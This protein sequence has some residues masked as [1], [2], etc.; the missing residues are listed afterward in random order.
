MSLV[1]TEWLFKNKDTVKIIDSS[2]H[3]P[4]ENR[5]GFEEYSSTHIPNSIYF[6]IDRNSDP[7]SNLPHMLPDKHL[8]GKI[9]SSLGISNKDRIVIYDNSK[10]LSS[11]RLWYTLLYFG[12]NKELVN[13]LNGGLEMWMKNNFPTTASQ[14]RIIQ[15]NYMAS[16]NRFMVKNLNEI[17][18]NIKSKVFKL[19]DARSKD[20]FDGKLKEPRDGVRSGSIENSICIPFNDVIKNDKTFKDNDKLKIIF[21]NVIN[22][23]DKNNVVFSCGSGIT[24]CVLALAY[25]L[26][27]NNY[28][29]TI[30]DGSWAEYGKIFK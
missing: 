11:C 26:I 8:W 29:P 7:S 6:D 21:H 23:K 9:M 25:S 12:H 14:T 4:S 13:V 3:L 20:R 27:N 15:S 16:E 1:S 28:N 17:N 18:Q 24:S 22:N 10:V 5:N 2:W 30:Y 19:I